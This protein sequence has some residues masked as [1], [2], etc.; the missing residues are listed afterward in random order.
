MKYPAGFL[1]LNSLLIALLLTA[2]GAL[3]QARDPEPANVLPHQ[4]LARCAYA[5][6]AHLCDA[7]NRAPPNVH[8]PQGETILAQVSRRQGPP[9]APPRRVYARGSYTR[10]GIGRPSGRRVLIGA[11]IGSLIGVAVGAKG[12]GGARVTGTFAAFGGFIGAG[13]GASIPSMA[14]R[15]PFWPAGPDDEMASIS[16]PNSPQAV[17]ASELS[18]TAPKTGPEVPV[19]QLTPKQIS[20]NP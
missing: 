14:T 13:M 11:V 18:P 7:V 19:G 12:S 17:A 5:P 8:E 9:A 20:L 4:A 10:M 1:T 6:T 15:S 2:S 16:T 3:A